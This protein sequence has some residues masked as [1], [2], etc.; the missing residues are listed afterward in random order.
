MFINIHFSQNHEQIHIW[1]TVTRNSTILEMAEAVYATGLVDESIP[2]D[3]LCLIDNSDTVIC[4]GQL[5][6][7][8]I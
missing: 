6:L 7:N 4:S 5:F 2:V 1:E 8:N 3:Y